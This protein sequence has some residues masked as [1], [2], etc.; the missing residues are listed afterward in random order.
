MISDS[1]FQA[2]HEYVIFVINQSI[3]G[4]QDS[5]LQKTTVKTGFPETYSFLDFAGSRRLW[6]KLKN[7]YSWSA[8]N[9]L[10]NDILNKKIKILLEFCVGCT[11][12][13]HNKGKWNLEEEIPV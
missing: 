5:I 3:I 4:S 10:S 7:T 13:H 2:E 12:I 1:V 8:Q 9:S 11:L 6:K